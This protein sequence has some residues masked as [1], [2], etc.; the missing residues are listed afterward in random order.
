MSRHAAVVTLRTTVRP[1][2]VARAAREPGVHGD[3]RSPPPPARIRAAGC[4]GPNSATTRDA[5][6]LGDVQEPRVVRHVLQGQLGHDPGQFGWD[7]GRP[8]ITTPIAIAGAAAATSIAGARVRLA[9]AQQRRDVAPDRP[10]RASGE[11]G[12]PRRPATRFESPSRLPARRAIGP[13]GGGGFTADRTAEPVRRER[14]AEGLQRV[15]NIRSTTVC[16]R[17]RPSARVGRSFTNAKRRTDCFFGR[18]SRRSART[19]AKQATDFGPSPTD[20]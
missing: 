1:V 7:P 18:R 20:R 13:S 17:H 16:E 10:R 2:Q 15:A 12:E 5:T 19:P 14:D 9:R 6:R 8:A 11:L 3:S 4:V